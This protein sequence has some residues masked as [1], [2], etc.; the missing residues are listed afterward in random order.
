VVTHTNEDDLAK[1]TAGAL[2]SA[3][4]QGFSAVFVFH[5]QLADYSTAYSSSRRPWAPDLAAT[6]QKNIVSESNKGRWN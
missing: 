4:D 3:F 1:S 5:F 6:A 2:L